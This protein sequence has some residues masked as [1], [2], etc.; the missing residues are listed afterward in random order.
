MYKNIAQKHS[1]QC[2]IDIEDWTNLV[3]F[4]IVD[5]TNY[6]WD[7]VKGRH[8]VIAR[9]NENDSYVAI[10]DDTELFHMINE[11]YQYDIGSLDTSNYVSHIWQYSGGKLSRLSRL[12]SDGKCVR[13]SMTLFFS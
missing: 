13:Y 2:S 10:V 5:Y 7:T 12:D 11:H 6:N 4:I 8:N 1:F 3:D 9:C